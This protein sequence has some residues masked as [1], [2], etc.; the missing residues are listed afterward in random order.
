MLSLKGQSGHNKFEGLGSEEV[1]E[2]A[3]SLV[4]VLYL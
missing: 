1:S 4:G 3:K 2:V